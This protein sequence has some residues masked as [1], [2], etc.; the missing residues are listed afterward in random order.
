MRAQPPILERTSVRQ[1]LDDSCL[2]PQ[3]TLSLLNVLVHTD[4]IV[5]Q[6][7]KR[8]SLHK[9][10]PAQLRNLGE[11]KAAQTTFRIYRHFCEGLSEA[12]T[13]ERNGIVACTTLLAT[14][15]SPP[16]CTL[17]VMVNALVYIFIC[18]ALLQS[19]RRHSR[20]IAGSKHWQEG[21]SRDN[22]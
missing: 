5:S 9:K 19:K 6:R 4:D 21:Y 18:R 16:W 12:I 20:G 7:Q 17:V 15:S 1:M 22:V 3:Q 11:M 13:T 2:G 14:I 8:Q 10:I